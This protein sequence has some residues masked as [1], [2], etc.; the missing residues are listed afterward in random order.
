MFDGFYFEYPKV[1]FVIFFFIACAT[2]CRMKLPS[3]YFPHSSRFAKES[4]G[5]SKLLFLLKW[6]SIVMIIFAFMS[7]VKDEPYE[8]APKKGY[9]IALILDSSES[10]SSKGFDSLNINASKFDVVKSI[11]NDFIEKRKNDNIGVVVFGAYSFIASPLTYDKHILQQVVDQMYISIAGRFTALYDALAQGVNLLKGS[12]A[13]S[14]IAILLTDGYNTPEVT[15]IP[16][17]AVLEMAKKE[18]IKVYTVGIGNPGEYDSDLLLAIAQATGGKA[19]GASNASQLQSV[20]EDIDR[21]EKSEIKSQSYTNVRYYYFY[22]LFIGLI[23]LMMYV[24]F[25]NKRGHE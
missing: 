1:F 15:K 3:F 20:Y 21:L 22:P 6:I 13:K 7:P 2:L 11:V 25:M 16:L 23:V 10:M 12:K 5:K 14:K 18:H 8:I 17:K 9:D 19:Y 24:Y 4:V